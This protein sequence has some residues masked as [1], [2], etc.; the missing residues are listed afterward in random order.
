MKEYLRKVSSLLLVLALMLSL[1]IPALATETSGSGGDSGNGENES[2]SGPGSITIDNA[3]A[4]QTYTIYRIFDLVSSGSN[5]NGEGTYVYKV[6]TGW[7]TFIA[8]DEIKDYVSV[9][10]GH[11]TWVKKEDNK[12][13]GMDEFAKLAKKYAADNQNIT[14][15]TKTADSTTVTFTGLKLGYYL[16]DSSLGTLCSLDTTNPS[17]TIKEKNG[18]PGN[19]KEVQ[20]DSTSVYGNKNTA[21]I[22]QIVYFR[23]TITAQPGAEGYTFYD[24]MSDGLTF[25]N[26]PYNEDTNPGGLRVV[27]VVDGVE[28]LVNASVT[29]DGTK[30]N[31]ELDTPT[32][33]SDYTFKIKFDQDFCNSLAANQEIIIYYS[34]TLNKYAAVNE[35]G[36]KNE[37]KLKYGEN[38]TTVTSTTTTYTWDINILKYARQGEGKKLL[39]GAKFVLYKIVNGE[40]QYISIDRDTEEIAWIAKAPD[41]DNSAAQPTTF[42]SDAKGEITIRGLDSDTYYLE[43]TEPPVGYNNLGGP[44]IIEIDENGNIK[45]NGQSVGTTRI[46]EVENIK[47]TLLPSTGGAGTALFYIV[48]GILAVGAAVL[49]VTKRRMR[50]EDE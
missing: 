30:I 40:K 24:T 43:E 8:S 13:I 4:G 2:Q 11:V 36:N 31:Y 26:K 6:A 15:L 35:D 39:E 46:I 50:N 25:N 49:L 48:G 21:D 7:E 14:Y 18:V 33:S 27:K 29:N 42:T 45:A 34:A 3:I 19:A 28:K 41:T 1:A 5:S 38:Q 16:L 12:N 22:G 23:S 47:G 9:A 10:D 32:D 37:S 44:I 20:E 17:V